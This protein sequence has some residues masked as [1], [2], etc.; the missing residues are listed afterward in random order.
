[1]ENVLMPYTLLSASWSL[2][3]DFSIL[4]LHMLKLDFLSPFTHKD[5]SSHSL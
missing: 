4:F 2:L 3:V 5:F 1:M